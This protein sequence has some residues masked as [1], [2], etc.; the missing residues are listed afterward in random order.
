M[1]RIAYIAATVAI[2]SCAA[3][4][5][6]QDVSS[7]TQEPPAVANDN[8]NS[9]TDNG[10]GMDTNGQSESGAPSGLTRLD[11][12]RQLY[13]VERDGELAHLNQTIYKGN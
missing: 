11:V 1:I 7:G 13:R 12:E 9:V 8:L 10:V 2:M 4:A 3:P 5:F 6:A